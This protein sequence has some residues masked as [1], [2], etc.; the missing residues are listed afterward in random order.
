MCVSIQHSFFTFV[1]TDPVCDS[2]S[3]L[4][5]DSL[6]CIATDSLCDGIGDCEDGSD[7]DDCVDQGEY[8]NNVWVRSKLPFF[9]APTT[10]SS[11]VDK[12]LCLD[13]LRCIAT[14]SVCDGA[15]D[16]LDASDESRCNST[17]TAS[18]GG[19]LTEL[20]ESPFYNHWR[21]K[22]LSD[23]T[24]KSFPLLMCMCITWRC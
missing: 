1:C 23:L 14:E 3:F 16:C 6:R 8:L 10:I 12:F 21:L 24:F 2:N 7:E 11:C 15:S 19:K 18:G 9:L 20:A 5:E 4:C 13:S 17:D 22:D